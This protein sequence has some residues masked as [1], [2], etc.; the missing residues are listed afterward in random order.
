MNILRKLTVFYCCLLSAATVAQKVEIRGK[1]V[2]DKNQPLPYASVFLVHSKKGTI[3]N[4]NGDFALISVSENDVLKVSSLGYRTVK[5]N[6]IPNTSFLKIVL[7]HMNTELEEVVVTNLSAAELLKK[8]VEKISENYEQKPF[9]TKE[10][11]RAKLYEKDTLLYMEETLFN[12]VKSYKSSFEDKYFLEKNRNFKFNENS[13]LRNIGRYD[14]VKLANKTFNN[15]FF[16]RNN[17]T[18]LYG[19]SFDN[20]PVYVLSITPKDKNDERESKIYIDTEN[21]AFLRFEL[22]MKSGD[23]LVAQYQNIDGKYYLTSGH[24][25]HI[26]RK[27]RRELPAVSDMVVTD[28]LNEFSDNEIQG[29]NVNPRNDRLAV[30]QTQQ[31][32]SVFWKQ[33]NVLLPD[34]AVQQTVINYQTQLRDTI[35]ALD[36]LEYNAYLTKLYTPNL[37]LFVSSNWTKDFAALNQNSVSINHTVNNFIFKKTGNIGLIY[38]AVYYLL[39]MPLE[40]TIAEQRLLSVDGLHA[41]INPFVFNQTNFSYSYG[42]DN[43]VLN[44]YKTNNYGNFMRLHTVRN[45]G[46]YVKAQILEEELAKVNLKNKNNQRDF[47]QLYLTELLLHKSFAVYNP[48]GKDKKAFSTNENKQPLIIDRN[49][50]WVKYLYKPDTEF[51]R[52]VTQDD[53]DAEENKY[54]KRSAWFSWLNFISPQMIGIPKFKIDKSTEFTFN[55]NYLRVPFGEM[56]GQ[57]I[58]LITNYDQLH[59]IYLKQ[60]KNFNKTTVGIGY[61]L[62]DL[63]LFRTIFVTTTLDYWQQPSENMFFDNSFSNG[64]HV[65]QMFEYQ[66]FSKKY[67]RTNHFSLFLGYDYKTKGY[68]PESFFLG[69][70]FDV[71]AGFKWNF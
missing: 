33:H 10:F 44:T 71:K 43:N 18:Y 48:F 7:Q 24:S 1:V 47:L 30:Y 11:Y 9:L 60:Y 29:V 52:H 63:K 26:N 20:K 27:L 23:Q 67:T 37:S 70:N 4:E 56:F 51:N 5:Q 40:E 69:K 68:M 28:I 65:G 38:S 41:K 21:L 64:F 45:D 6:I 25:V 55:L 16:K 12:I 8:A 59:G 42:I 39:A 31:N 66:M 3:S 61:K 57:N 46:H 35:K 34:S 15:Y 2:N 50:S 54:L 62:F 49:R 17:I 58:W 53:L 22:N 32:D 19:T 13:R 36:T 14:I